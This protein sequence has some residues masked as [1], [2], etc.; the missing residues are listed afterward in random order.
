MSTT[1]SWSTRYDNTARQR[2]GRQHRAV[3]HVKQSGDHA[4]HRQRTVSCRRVVAQ[5]VTLPSH[6]LQRGPGDDTRKHHEAVGSERPTLAPLITAR[7]AQT[8]KALRAGHDSDITIVCARRAVTRHRGGRLCRASAAT[9]IGVA[10]NLHNAQ[11]LEHRRDGRC[12]IA[13]RAI[14][15]TAITVTIIDT[16]LGT[17]ATTTVII[18]IIIIPTVAIRIT[19]VFLVRGVRH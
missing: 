8:H 5:P 9:A 1:Q 13:R 18:T 11:R 15:T 6:S 7:L 17:I 16:I 12:T 3:G 19:T 14:V 2:G 4:V 10:L